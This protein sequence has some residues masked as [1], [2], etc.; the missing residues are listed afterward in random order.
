[1]PLR[2]HDLRR[3]AALAGF[4]LLAACS[5]DVLDPASPRAADTPRPSR[6]PRPAAHAHPQRR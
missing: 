5:R 2:A 1:M 4:M 3:G 6:P